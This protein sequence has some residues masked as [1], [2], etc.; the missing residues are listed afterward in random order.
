VFQIF[1]VDGAQEEG[2]LVVPHRGKNVNYLTVRTYPICAVVPCVFST[3]RSW[4]VA[5]KRGGCTCVLSQNQI[6]ELV[7]DKRR[8]LVVRICLYGRRRG[9][10][11]TIVF[12]ITTQRTTYKT[13]FLRHT[14]QCL[15]PSTQ[16]ALCFKNLSCLVLEILFFRKKNVQEIFW[17]FLCYCVCRHQLVIILLVL[18]QSEPCS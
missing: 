11:T 16:N 6:R 18:I 1:V 3:A 14:E 5:V 17:Q 13:S 4:D 12:C 10:T 9:A 8:V 7:M 2:G 15:I